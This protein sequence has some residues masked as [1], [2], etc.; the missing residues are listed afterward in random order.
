M[1]SSNGLSLERGRGCVRGCNVCINGRGSRCNKQV[2]N[3]ICL[4]PEAEG[5]K[6]ALRS[7]LI[8]GQSAPAYRP[9]HSS[10]P[11]P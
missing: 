1:L 4:V 2:A 8:T 10:N 11:S 3:T 6:S 9:C 7:A 5:D